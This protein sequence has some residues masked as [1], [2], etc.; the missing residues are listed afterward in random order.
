MPLD[1]R[2]IATEDFAT[3]IPGDAMDSAKL[4]GM[5]RSTATD[6]AVD[7]DSVVVPRVKRQPVSAYMDALT[8]STVPRV[9]TN[10]TATVLAGNVPHRRSVRMGAWQVSGERHALQ[11]VLP[12]VLE[13][14][15]RE[16]ATVCPVVK[17]PRGR[18][19][20]RQHS[21]NGLRN[22]VAICGNGKRNIYVLTLLLRGICNALLCSNV[23]RQ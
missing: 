1:A 5:D 21:S 22:C 18:C 12:V 4:V 19:V 8:D 11:G 23:V 14:V 9:Q 17:D 6:H 16:M 20:S 7:A 3:R 10:A 13:D 2:G 15:Y